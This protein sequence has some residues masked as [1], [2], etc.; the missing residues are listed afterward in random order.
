M[1]SVHNH[2]KLYTMN[3]SNNTQGKST[4]QQAKEL[5]GQLSKFKT[6]DAFKKWWASLSPAQ[7]GATVGLIVGSGVGG[8]AFFLTYKSF[9]IGASIANFIIYTVLVGSCTT[10][11]AA[12]C[13]TDKE[14]YGKAV[15]HMDEI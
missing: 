1:V 8:Y 7:K 3:T 12:A 6:V 10:A 15:S 5:A 14:Y 4:E 2:Q 11:V 13:Y 9:G